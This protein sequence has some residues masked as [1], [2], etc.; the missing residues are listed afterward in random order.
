MQCAQVSWEVM[1]ARA[2][3]AVGQDIGVYVGIQQ[4]EYGGL[5]SPTLTT[6]GPFSATGGPFSVA[7]GRLSFTY[8]LR[9][10]AVHPATLCDAAL[11]RITSSLCCH[12]ALPCTSQPITLILLPK[13][14]R[15]QAVHATQHYSRVHCMQLARP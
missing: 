5:A 6:I 3:A 12:H 1:H 2:A 13:F 7:A 11:C 10:P 14:S 4:M 15:P 9:G 8:G